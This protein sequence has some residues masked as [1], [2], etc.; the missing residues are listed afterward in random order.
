M[1]MLWCTIMQPLAPLYRPGEQF[2]I[3]AAGLKAWRDSECFQRV[4]GAYRNYPPQSLQ[5]DEARALLHHLVVMRRPEFA[6]EIGTHRA[7]TSEVLARALWE[8]G[9]GHLDTI[10]PFEG[11]RCPALIAGLPEAL[12]QRITYQPVS[13]AAH[14]DRAIARGVSY[15]FV[16]VDG[17]HEFEFAL[18]DLMCAARLMRPSGL[19]VLDNIEQPGP[20]F[21]TKVFLKDNPEW[22][23][24]AHAVDEL[25]RALPF[26]AVPPSFPDTKFYLLQAPPGYIVKNVP[27]SFGAINSNWD[28][29]QGVKLELAE[30][31]EGSF[32]IQVFVRTFGLPEPEEVEAQKSV[33]LT[34]HPEAEDRSVRVPFDKPL[35]GSPQAPG[36]QR[37]I[38]IVVAYTGKGT[39]GLKVPPLPYPAQFA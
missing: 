1:A 3:S 16:L 22:R 14:F 33:D 31:V 35:R 24:I 25:D 29:I 7:G 12:R 36:L 27:R 17:S 38:E 21:A 23:D 28:E 2:E 30:P 10:D 13:S 18:F 26:S 11:H 9:F 8:N 4:F 15:D 20:R 39:A 6:L 5:S 37:R 34:M 32:H 19:V